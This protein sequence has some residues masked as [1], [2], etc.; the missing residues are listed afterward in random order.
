MAGLM[1]GGLNGGL[2]ILACLGVGLA[3]GLANGARVAYA[4]MPPIIVTLATTGIARGLALIYTGG[5]SINGL[6]S[7]MRFFGAGSVLGVQTPIVV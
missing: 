2:G 6:P 1:A 4:K 5:Y 3:F 7:W